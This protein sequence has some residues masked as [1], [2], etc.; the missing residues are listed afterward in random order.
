MFTDGVSLLLALFAVLLLVAAGVVLNFASRRGTRVLD[1]VDV[2]DGLIDSYAGGLRWPLPA[3]LGTTNMPPVLVGLELYPWGL[4]IGARWSFLYPFMPA[5]YARYE[6]IVVAEHAKRGMRLSKT[7]SHGVRLRSQVNG[8][9]VIFWTSNWNGLLDTLEAQ[10]VSVVRQAM[11]TR[12]W[13]NE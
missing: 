3:G 8:A 12:A 9:P 5:W 4:R 11:P 1:E 10:G 2:S 13:S 6:E 7:G